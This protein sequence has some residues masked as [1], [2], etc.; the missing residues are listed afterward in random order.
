MCCKSTEKNVVTEPCWVL[1]EWSGVEE[2]YLFW[3][4]QVIHNRSSDSHATCHV[5]QE[6]R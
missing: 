2:I 3:T 6:G 1:L 4:L 5:N